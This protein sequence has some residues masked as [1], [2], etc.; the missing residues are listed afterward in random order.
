MARNRWSRTGELAKMC[1]ASEEKDLRDLV[2]EE[3]DEMT[4]IK[5]GN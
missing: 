4:A 3:K 5:D 1:A 2:A